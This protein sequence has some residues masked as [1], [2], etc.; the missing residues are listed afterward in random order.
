MPL[1]VLRPELLKPCLG[2]FCLLLQGSFGILERRELRGHLLGELFLLLLQL[3]R[4]L[5]FS[6]KRRQSALLRGLVLLHSALQQLKLLPEPGGP[7]A[8]RGVGDGGGGLCRHRRGRPPRHGG[9]GLEVRGAKLCAVGGRLEPQPNDGGV[10]AGRSDP[11]RGELRG[12]G[13]VADEGSLDIVLVR[14]LLFQSRMVA[15]AEPLDLE[16]CCF[17]WCGNYSPGD[18][19]C[20]DGAGPPQGRPDRMGAEP[21]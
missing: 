9:G 19:R 4:P 5:L 7:S 21:R 3:P 13:G 1:C 6:T 14:W 12:G 8:V 16:G 20:C 2:G 10:R 18:G 15:S 17:L 11:G